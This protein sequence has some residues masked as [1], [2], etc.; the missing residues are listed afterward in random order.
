[1]EFHLLPFGIPYVNILHLLPKTT[2]YSCLSKS[3]PETIYCEKFYSQFY[4]NSIVNIENSIVNNENSTVNNEN[5]ILKFQ[6]AK[7][8]LN[9]CIKMQNLSKKFF[10]FLRFLKKF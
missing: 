8:L 2:I 10:S 6:I 7:E 9:I 3:I 5:S 4:D 1:M